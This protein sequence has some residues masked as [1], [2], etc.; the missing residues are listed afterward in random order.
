M[1]EVEAPTNLPRPFSFSLCRTRGLQLT[2]TLTNATAK[3]VALVATLAFVHLDYLRHDGVDVPTDPH[4]LLADEEWGYPAHGPFAFAPGESRTFPVSLCPPPI[5]HVMHVPRYVG[6]GEYRARLSYRY[7][8][9]DLESDGT[10]TFRGRL[11]G[12]EI[13]I[14]VR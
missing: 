12:P 1:I 5:D 10:P 6:P 14:R 2:A 7:E 3:R 4:E 9:T 8:G 11:V 13:T